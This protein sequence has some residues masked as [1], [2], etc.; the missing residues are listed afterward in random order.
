MKYDLILVAIKKNVP[1]FY[2][3]HNS[4]KLMSSL[5]KICFPIYGFYI[6]LIF[7]FITRKLIQTLLSFFVAE[8]QDLIVLMK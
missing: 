6:Y 3:L 4:R 7:N 1:S 2:N 5:C 8:V